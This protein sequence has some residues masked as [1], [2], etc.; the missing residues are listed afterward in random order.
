MSTRFS[1]KRSSK[2]VWVLKIALFCGSRKLIFKSSD[3]EM[4]KFSSRHLEN[5]TPTITQP[6]RMMIERSCYSCSFMTFEIIFF[7]S[8]T[9]LPH[10]LLTMHIEIPSQKKIGSEFSAFCENDKC[11]HFFRDHADVFVQCFETIF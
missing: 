10:I 6:L 7:T 4:S 1:K 11:E 5:S 8:P 9:C 2:A 3:N